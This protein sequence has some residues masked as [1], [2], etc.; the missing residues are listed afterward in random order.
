MASTVRLMEG[1]DLGQVEKLIGGDFP[2]NFLSLVYE[3]DGSILGW[4][5]CRVSDDQV[6]AQAAATKGISGFS[7]KRLA[8]AMDSF[9][10][11]IGLYF[12]VFAVHVKRK[13]WIRILDEIGIYERYATRS[14]HHWFIRRLR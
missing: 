4:I 12:Y 8:E 2:P 1:R 7:I 10:I 14:M 3:R 9:L 6:V 13:K 11:K 5:C